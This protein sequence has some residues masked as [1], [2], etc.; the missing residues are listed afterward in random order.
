MGILKIFK[1]FVSAKPRRAFCA[2]VK[3]SDCGEVVRVGI[4]RSSDLQIEYNGHN[5][6]HC[7]TIKKEIIGKGCFNLMKISLALTKE[8]GLLFSDTQG[9]K[10]I[11]FEKDSR[12]VA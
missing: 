3:C 10:L 4:D 6:E 7:Y 1:N 5:P 12:D 9:C 2:V 11:S 8:A